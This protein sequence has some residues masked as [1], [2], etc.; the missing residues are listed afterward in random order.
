MKTISN[1][2]NKLLI[3]FLVAMLIFSLIFSSRA[4]QYSFG[5]GSNLT[6]FNFL[7][8]D[9]ISRD[10]MKRG[11]GN[12]FQINVDYRFL[13]TTK[14][15][16]QSSDR[17]IYFNQHKRLAS[18]LSMLIFNFGVE[19]NQYN[20]VGDI[21]NIDFN[22]QTNFVGLSSGFGVR[23]PVLAGFSLSA[24]G[25]ISGQKIVQGNQQIASK[26]YDLT[27]D[28]Q[29]LPIQIMFGYSVELQKK[30]GEKFG[31][32]ISYQQMRTDHSANRG[33][34]TLNFQPSSISFGIKVLK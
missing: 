29:F 8:S 13:D 19:S 21:Q 27:I 16:T 9:G 31:V 24:Q 12:H 1:I 5:A 25:R 22:Y 11:S 4:Q 20:A 34:A 14:F 23:I 26:Y 10:F 28:P 17:A 7:N 32:F 18:L 2:K 15:L 3:L 6:E 33:A 30:I